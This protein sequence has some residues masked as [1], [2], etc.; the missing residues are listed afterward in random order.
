[1]HKRSS[2]L[3]TAI[4]IAIAYVPISAAVST[5]TAQGAG[6]PATVA[7][8]LCNVASA[9]VAIPPDPYKTFWLEFQV[10]TASPVVNAAFVGVNDIPGGTAVPPAFS[11][12]VSLFI[13]RTTVSGANK[14][15]WIGAVNGDV[16][17]AKP[18]RGYVNLQYQVSDGHSCTATYEGT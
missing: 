9:S 10:P 14:T 16:R 17:P 1:M 18:E 12:N 2:L 4:G 8:V 15:V 3:L 6:D 7:P 5:A 11:L 13:D